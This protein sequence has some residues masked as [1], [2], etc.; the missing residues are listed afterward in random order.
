MGAVCLFHH[1]HRRNLHDLHN[2]DIDHLVEEEHGEEADDQQSEHATV[3]VDDEHG[4]EKNV[5]KKFWEL[6]SSSFSSSSSVSQKR[7]RGR[8]T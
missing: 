2:G 5:R 7:T 1:Q 4:Y 3:V 6:S 8:A